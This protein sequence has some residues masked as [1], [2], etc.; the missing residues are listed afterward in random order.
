MPRGPATFYNR[1]AKRWFDIAAS[2]T[3]LVALGPLIGAVSLAVLRKHGRPILFRQ[4]RTGVNGEPFEI[5]K[6]RTMTDERDASGNLLP[7]KMRLTALGKW[8]RE[9]SIDELPELLNVLRGEMSLVGPRPLLHRYMR[10]YNERQHRRHEA[11]PG[12]TGWVAVNGRNTT[13]WEQRFEMD[14]YYVEN[15]GPLLD[16]K[17]LLRTIVTVLSREGVDPGFADQMPEFGTPAPAT[18]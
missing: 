3:A 12:I 1:F 9:T 4:Q 14:V 11:R 8:L 18:N 5:L 6:F 13:T 16:M 10:H 7:D 17:I 2:A 15:L